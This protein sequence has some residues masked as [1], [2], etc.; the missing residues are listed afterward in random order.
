VR[1]PL[2]YSSEQEVLTT[3]DRNHKLLH[4][5]PPGFT[6]LASLQ[7]A[8]RGRGSNVWV[9]PIGCLLFSTC[10]RHPAS[11]CERSPVVFV[12]YIAALAVVE[13]VKSYAP[14]YEDFPIHIKWPN[15][16][17]AC[18]LPSITITMSADEAMP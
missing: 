2:P 7:T 15:D 12:Q 9:S 16:I 5:L 1:V 4:T 3:A 14:G 13:A 18:R 8:G 11:A 6:A 17:C 10:I